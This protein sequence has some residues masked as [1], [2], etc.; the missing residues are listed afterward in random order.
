MKKYSPFV[1][2]LMGVLLNNNP[3]E[4]GGYKKK[5]LMYFN[6]SRYLGCRSDDVDLN[7]KELINS[8]R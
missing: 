1:N 2:Y 5:G 6:M 7:I 8:Q 3:N 4:V